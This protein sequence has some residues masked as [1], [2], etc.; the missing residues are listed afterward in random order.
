MRF[1]L[2]QHAQQMLERRAIPQNMIDLVLYNPQQIIHDEEGTVIYQSQL[3][4]GEGKIV[5]LRAVIATDRDPA[6]VITVYYTSQIK[7][8]WR[9]P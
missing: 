3:A 7:K 6:V 9:V 5:L 1:R 8:Y 2:S 4:F